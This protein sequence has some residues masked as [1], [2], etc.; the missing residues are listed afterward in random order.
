MG[1][2]HTALSRPPS[3]RP[4]GAAAPRL[5]R[6]VRAERVAVLDAAARGAAAGRRRPARVA[7]RRRPRRRLHGPHPD[8]PGAGGEAEGAARGHGRVL[9]PEGNRVVYDR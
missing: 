8:I 9:V 1:Q 7:A 3:Y 2:A 6:A 4:G 5:V